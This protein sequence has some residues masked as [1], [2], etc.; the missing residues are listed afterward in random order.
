MEKLDDFINKNRNDFDSA[1]LSKNHLHKFEKKLQSTS[2]N[3]NRYYWFTVA[4]AIIILI[5]FSITYQKQNF[6]TN[7]TEKERLYL[8]DVSDKYR[9]VEEFYKK[10]IDDKINEFEQLDCKIDIKQRKMLKSELKQLDDDYILLQKELKHNRNDKRIINAMLDNYQN[11]IRF[12]DLV[13]NQIKN[14]C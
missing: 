13:V 8:S 2:N 7:S 14:N 5:S 12:L 4:A 11:K 3:N 9:E 10:N 6:K 1:K